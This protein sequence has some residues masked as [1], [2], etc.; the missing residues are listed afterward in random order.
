MI[1]LMIA[2]ILSWYIPRNA[3]FYDTYSLD[4]FA[5]ILYISPRGI[6]ILSLKMPLIGERSDFNRF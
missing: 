3:L 6:F 1:V 4:L 5:H 2:L